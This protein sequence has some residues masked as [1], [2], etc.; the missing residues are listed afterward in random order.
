VIDTKE[1][2][3]KSNKLGDQVIVKE[4]RTL[5]AM[6]M[7][8]SFLLQMKEEYLYAI[9]KVN[10]CEQQET[11]VCDEKQPHSDNTTTIPTLDDIKGSLLCNTVM[12]N[13]LPDN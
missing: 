11:S 6:N 2:I 3:H 12:V 10:R 7:V 5:K 9:K 8:N 1:R 4:E 13:F